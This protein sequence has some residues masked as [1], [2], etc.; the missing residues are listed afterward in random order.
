MVREIRG[1]LS[2]ANLDRTP[3]QVRGSWRVRSSRPRQSRQGL[4]G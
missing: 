1:V 4:E 2:L 3:E